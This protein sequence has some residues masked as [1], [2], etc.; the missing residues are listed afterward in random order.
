VLAHGVERRAW[1]AAERRE[2]DRE[3]RATPIAFE[4]ELAL[5]PASVEFLYE[6]QPLS[7]RNVWR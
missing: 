3:D 5:M 6:P 4:Q 1:S 7:G 2:N